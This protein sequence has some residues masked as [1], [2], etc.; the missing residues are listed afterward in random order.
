[1]PN[2]SDPSDIHRKAAEAAAFLSEKTDLRP[3][4]AVV[5]GSGLGAFATALESPIAIPFA[6]IPHFP[7]ST[8]PGHSGRLVI[9][10]IGE[11][12][13]A[14][15]QGRVHA[16]EGYSSEQV[17][18]PVRVLALFGIRGL[19]LTN[20]AGGICESFAQGDLVLISDHINFT[21]HN[22]VSGPNDDRMG[23]RF[24]DMTEAYSLRL[25]K[26]SQA[27]A[28]NGERPMQEGVYLSLLGPSFETPAEI[29]AFRT[30]GADLVGM[31]TVQENI[32]AR[33]MGLEVL[34]ISCVTNM[35]AGI[36]GEPLSHEE[37]METGQR[38]EARL[39]A[40]LEQMLPQMSK[41]IQGGAK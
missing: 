27:I 8:V 40:L 10:K 35:A 9:G 1:M 38:V 16:Y 25:R 22:P 20:A 11:T 28:D 34:G 23:P 12:P 7:R 41:M 33:H 21:G 19:V 17:T 4:V 13:V 39:A 14:V 6:A 31:S 36:Q 29:R 32:V 3:A 26:L 37:V 30:W 2:P 18:F 24:F 5:L 15:M